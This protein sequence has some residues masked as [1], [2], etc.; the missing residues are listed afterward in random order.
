MIKEKK[1]KK[2]S[3]FV[4]NLSLTKTNYLIFGL[5]LLVIIVGYFVMASGDTYS[6]R[7]LSVAP[8]ILLLGYLIIIPISILYRKDEPKDQNKSEQ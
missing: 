8:V 4:K 1:I 6:F 2:S 7:S 5:G 3:Q